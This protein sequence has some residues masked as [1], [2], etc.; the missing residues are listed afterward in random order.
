MSSNSKST[1][2]LC[3]ERQYLHCVIMGRTR[4]IRVYVSY[5]AVTVHNTSSGNVIIIRLFRTTSSL[6]NNNFDNY[7]EFIIK[8]YDGLRF[9]INILLLLY[10]FFWKYSRVPSSEHTQR[11]SY[12]LHCRFPRISYSIIHILLYA[13]A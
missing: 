9:L 5:L 2:L 7:R 3:S 11:L 4:V 8:T 1:I 12:C 10:F 13:I 6:H